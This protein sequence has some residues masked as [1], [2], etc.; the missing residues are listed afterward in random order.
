MTSYF[1]PAFV[2]VAIFTVLT[3]LAYP[4]A[5]TGLANIAFP[6]SAGGSLIVRDGTVAGSRLI[7]QVFASERYFHGRPS[8]AGQAGYDAAAS[9]GSNLGPL[10]KKLLDRVA[11]DVASLREPGGGPVPADAVTTSASGLDPHISPAY[12]ELQ[13]ERVAKARGVSPDRVRAIVAQNLDKPDFGLIGE[14]RINVVLLNLAL[15][16]AFAPASG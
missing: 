6:T 7:G 8:A 16:A 11:A 12:A 14:E 15:D 10:S 1:R 5:M 4:L 13:V 9:S 2:L 3:G